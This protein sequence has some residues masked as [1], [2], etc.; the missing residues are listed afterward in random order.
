MWFSLFGS[1]A[2]ERP[3]DPK[4]RQGKG[5]AAASASGPR[6]S[7]TTAIR[8][9]LRLGLRETL[10]RNGIPATWISAEALRS[11]DGSGNQWTH[12]RL[13]IHHW[14]VRLLRCLVALESDL[15]RRITL[16]DGAKVIKTR[17][18][19]WAFALPDASACPPLPHS[20]AWAPLAPQQASA[21]APLAAATSR[22]AAKPLPVQAPASAAP[23]GRLFAATEPAD[24]VALAE[25][26]RARQP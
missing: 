14:D 3:G 25:S 18:V 7:G 8:E 2:G 16:L 5:R 24:L 23:R 13:N 12:V 1:S 4:R 10:L 21:P 22:P 20:S 17:G 15:L 6:G 9:I 26:R 19:S 11:Q